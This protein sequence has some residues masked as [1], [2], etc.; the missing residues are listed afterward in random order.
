MRRER[1]DRSEAS[2]A[3]R[4][5]TC[6]ASR[7]ARSSI[8]RKMSIVARLNERWSRVM[9]C[10]SR[11]NVRA[12]LPATTRLSPRI[13]VMGGTEAP[14]CA[15][16]CA[17]ASIPSTGSHPPRSR[18]TGGRVAAGARAWLR[19]R[20]FSRMRCMIS[21]TRISGFFTSSMP[22]SSASPR[23][24]VYTEAPLQF[25]E[26][27]RRQRRIFAAQE[28]EQAAAGGLECGAA[29][30]L[31]PPPRLLLDR[32]PQSG[33]S[34]EPERPGA[35]LV[36]RAESEPADAV[37]DDLALAAAIDHYGR[38]TVLHRLG[39]RHPEVL[40]QLRFVLVQSA[41]VPEDRRPRVQ[42]PQLVEGDVRPHLD[43]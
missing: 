16:S 18:A 1:S 10:A 31:A 2:S 3:R 15:T 6:P 25:V 8:V 13:R 40:D 11:R 30:E 39:G 24:G 28:I 17:R 23:R 35:H 36:Q 27:A 14:T 9:T 38:A 12:T 34:D 43:C 21:S 5:A 19:V 32:A 29:E 33:I 7:R 26:I 37:L 20:T 4:A 42:V 22:S 41:S